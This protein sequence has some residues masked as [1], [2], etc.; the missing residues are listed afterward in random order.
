[1]PQA[2]YLRTD[3][4]PLTGL[5]LFPGNARKGD[6]RLILESLR[7]SGQYRPLIARQ[8]PDGLVVLAGNHTAQALA[9]HGRGPCPASIPTFSTPTAACGLCDGRPWEPSARVEVVDCDDATALR[10]GGVVVCSD[11]SG[12]NLETCNGA[13]DDCDGS[14]D[15][16]NPG[17]GV[18]CD[19]ADGDTCA[20]GVTV[21][22]AGTL[23]CN[24]STGTT[25]ET[26][27]GVDDDC[28]GE[29]DN[30]P[31]G[32]LCPAGQFCDNG[33]CNS[34]VDDNPP[35][36]E[37]TGPSGPPNEGGAPDD[38]C[39][40]RVGGARAEGNALPALLVL[41]GLGLLIIARRRRRA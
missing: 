37:P 12:S 30:G 10:T 1:M 25:V 35:S 38:G 36:T 17:G 6:V 4:V 39:G 16:G 24:D 23:T 2:T 40:C 22:T 14:V 31:P 9:L 13:D 19:G 34:L 21:C 18:A 27:N 32:G 28:D 29:I 15:E 5:T 33:R 20:E 7:T 11:T 41:S 26:C 3:V 8:M